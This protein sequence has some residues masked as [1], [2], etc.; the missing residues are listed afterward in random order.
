MSIREGD[1]TS[2]GHYIPAAGDVN[3]TTMLRR[4]HRLVF[5]SAS[6]GNKR[7]PS[8]VGPNDSTTTEISGHV[9]RSVSNGARGRYR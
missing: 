9:A 1:I 8:S 2:S 7:R 6:A 4:T 3:A 5:E